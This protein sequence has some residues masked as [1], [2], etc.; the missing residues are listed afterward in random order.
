MWAKPAHSDLIQAV[1][2]F[3]AA[4]PDVTA[5]AIE[6]RGRLDV[7]QVRQHDA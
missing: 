2:R 4:G 6:G 1:I 5:L 3:N 7:L